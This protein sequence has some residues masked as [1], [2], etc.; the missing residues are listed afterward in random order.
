M[1][2][3]LQRILPNAA[4]GNSATQILQSAPFAGTASHAAKA[5]PAPG[6]QP[7]ENTLRYVRLLMVTAANNNKYYEMKE[8][9]DGTFAVHYGRVGASQA[10]RS[11]PIKDWDSKLREKMAKGYVDHSSLIADAATGQEFLPIADA[12]VRK[13]MDELA[14][15]ARQSIFRN[16]HVAADQVTKRQVEKAQ[17]L[18]DELAGQLRP[19]KNSEAFNEKL[20]ELYQIIPRKMKNVRD[21]LIA[22][23]ITKKDIPA[24]EEMLANEQATLDVMRGEVDMLEEQKS[25]SAKTEQTLLDA[26]GL[27]AE[28]VTEGKLIRQIK[29]A[30]GAD[31]AR[32]SRAFK[33][34]N[35]R[36]QQQFDER[37]ASSH[38][39]KVELL[40]HGSRNENWLSILQ[41]GLVLRPANAVISGK[42]FGYGL[43]FA[44][45]CRKSLN[46]TSL[47]GSYWARGR[48]AKAWL[49]LYDVHLG[50]P[51]KIKKHE[52]WCC[53]LT[54][55]KLRQ[56][57]A[58]YD[59]VFAQGG[60]DLLNNEY[61]VYHENQCSI[62]YLVEVTT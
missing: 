29:S 55:D 18:L 6:E 11:Y 9:E 43:Y 45:K 25:Q 47:H 1:L 56:K 13:L 57:G 28:E 44:D 46:Y 32:F 16:Y 51:L 19:S 22:S 39:K 33:V 36:H 15:C 59:S 41:S 58:D 8:K 17:Q 30:M 53:E 21:H 61:I 14:A 12:A 34:T 37:L 7:G 54:Q 24:I 42:M 5:Q 20:L 48:Q 23:P 4:P 60:V 40:W 2:R 26:L 38:N 35:L 10:T 31:A 50:K 27:R 52:G 49:A 62:R 3:L